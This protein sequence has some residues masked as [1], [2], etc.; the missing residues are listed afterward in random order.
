MVNSAKKEAE[1]EWKTFKDTSV[2]GAKEV[3]GM[4]RKICGGRINGSE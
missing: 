4:R 3:C 1:E 2:S